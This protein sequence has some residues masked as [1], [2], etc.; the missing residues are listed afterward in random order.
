M[1][2]TSVLKTKKYARIYYYDKSHQNNSCYNIIIL[3][4]HFYARYKYSTITN[5]NQ[6]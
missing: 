4:T 2:K 1:V 5:Y 3:C 6:N